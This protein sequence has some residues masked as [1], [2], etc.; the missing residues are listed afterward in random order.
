MADQMAD[1][2]TQAVLNAYREQAAYAAQQRDALWQQRPHVPK[3]SFG[4]GILG[5]G[6]LGQAVAAALAPYGF[7]LLGWSRDR[8]TVAGVESFAGAAELRAFLA[9]T[10]VLV[11]LLPSTPQTRDLVD[12]ARLMQLPRGA[13]LVNIARGELVV[14]ADLI[15]VLDAGHLAGATL[16]VFREEPLPPGHPFWHHPRITLTPH[17]AAATLVEDSVAQIAAKIRRIE[18][19]LPISG[20][21]DRVRGY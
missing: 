18:Q 21:V 16:D 5:L 13:F 20:V 7:P 10:R 19:G 1:Y 2:V 14:D 3:R 12:R 9:R 11:C 4:V 8:K 17:V 6:L 15:S